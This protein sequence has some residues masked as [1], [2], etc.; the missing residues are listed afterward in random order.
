MDYIGKLVQNGTFEKLTEPVALYFSYVDIAK[1]EYYKKHKELIVEIRNFC[2]R[3]LAAY[4]KERKYPIVTDD[5]LL[6]AH[7]GA[8]VV[9]DTGIQ[10][11]FLEPEIAK[12]FGMRLAQDVD[13]S[14][15]A[16]PLSK[17]FAIRLEQLPPPVIHPQQEK[18]MF[19]Y[20]RHPDGF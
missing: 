17:I 10:T 14:G 3:E 9:S 4:L 19:T 2:K 13:D 11:P 7:P 8:I 16:K 5:S 20:L 18:T 15:F 12:D 1:Y 6:A